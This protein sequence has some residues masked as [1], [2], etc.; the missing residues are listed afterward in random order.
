LLYRQ[1]IIPVVPKV[2]KRRSGRLLGKRD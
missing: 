2:S 1:C